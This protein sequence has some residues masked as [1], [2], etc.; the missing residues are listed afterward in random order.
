M[1]SISVWCWYSV[2]CCL[3]LFT[4]S[5]VQLFVL[6]CVFTF[7]VPVCDVHYDLHIHLLCLSLSCI[8]SAQCCQCLWNVRSWLSLLFSLM[9]I[10]SLTCNTNTKEQFSEA[11]SLL[12]TISVFTSIKWKY[13]IIHLYHVG[14]IMCYLRYLCLFSYSGVQH[15][16]CCVSV[17]FAL[18]SVPCVASFS[19]LSI[20][21]CSFGIP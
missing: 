17:Y 14:G 18:S 1:Y 9:C 16:L 7:L 11:S 13:I 5:G 19:R 8:L 15:I 10:N 20:F 4:Y 12:F 3:C 2:L 6:L 21:D